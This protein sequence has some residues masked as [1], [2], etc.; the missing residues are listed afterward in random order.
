MSKIAVIG[1]S[2]LFPGAS[3]PAEFWDNLIHGRDNRLNLSEEQ[4]GVDP[5]QLYTPHKGVPDHLYSTRNG[6]ITNFTFDPLGFAIAPEKL[7]G[8]DSLYQ[9]SLYVARE[10]LADSG[11]LRK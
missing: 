9:W 3:T 2:C 8:L 6:H 10:A 11:Y 1:M 7:S 4:L 5:M